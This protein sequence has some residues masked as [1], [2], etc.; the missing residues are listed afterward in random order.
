MWYTHMVMKSTVA[1]TRGG[2]Q[3]LVSYE[4]IR[5]DYNAFLETYESKSV[6]LVE[7]LWSNFV[8]WC[9]CRAYTDI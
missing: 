1:P 9:A 2:R 3:Q 7:I 6:Q 4:E 5:N 8:S